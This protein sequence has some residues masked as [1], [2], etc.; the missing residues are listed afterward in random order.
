MSCDE[1]AADI[2]MTASSVKEI[3]FSGG[4]LLGD[5]RDD[6]GVINLLEVTIYI[7]IQILCYAELE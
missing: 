2:V 4:I 6:D 1:S 5:L 3:F 7:G